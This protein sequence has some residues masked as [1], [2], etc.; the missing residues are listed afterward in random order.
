VVFG[1]GIGR[2]LD[3]APYPGNDPEPDPDPDPEKNKTPTAQEQP[4]GTRR[5][6]SLRLKDSGAPARPMA[7]DCYL[8][9]EAGAG[10]GLSHPASRQHERSRWGHDGCPNER[11]RR[12]MP[13]LGVGRKPLFRK[14]LRGMVGRGEVV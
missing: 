9:I 8:D 1:I 3:L 14:G 10:T 4:R 11:V 6:H 12:G 13:E 5:G 7:Q 2:R